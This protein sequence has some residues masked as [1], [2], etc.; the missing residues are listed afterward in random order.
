M[1]KHSIDDQV[2]VD[3]ML[4][5]PG[6]VWFSILEALGPTIAAKAIDNMRDLGVLYSDNPYAEHFCN[7]L[8]AGESEA[9]HGRMLMKRGAHASEHVCFTPKSGHCRE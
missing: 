2:L 3:A 5:L 8:A 6:A 7:T 9:I 4:R 1:R